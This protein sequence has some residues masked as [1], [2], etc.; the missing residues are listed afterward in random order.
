MENH[1]LK[2]IQ[3][4]DWGVLD[5]ARALIRQH[6]LVADRIKGRTLDRLILVEHPPVVTIGRSGS[7]K[8]LRVAKGVLE[9]KGISL[10]KVDRGGRATFH[11]PGQLVVYPIVKIRDK[12]IHAFLK[13]L[14]NTVAEVLQDYQLVPEFKKGKPGLWVNGAKIASVGLSVRD[15]VTCHGIAL[16]VC[17]DPG[18]F[19]LIIP[20]GEKEERITSMDHEIDGLVD[21][22]IVKRR[23]VDHFCTQ[24]GYIPGNRLYADHYRAASEPVQRSCSIP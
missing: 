19:D 6:Q 22:S 18:W 11:G 23:F 14:L 10:H 21:I 24:L 20:C 2:E 17:T 5:Y 3:I 1:R 13:R 7:L 15:Q 4:I 9:Q 12:D 8:D 16:N